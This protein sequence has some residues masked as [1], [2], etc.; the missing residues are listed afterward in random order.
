MTKD[1]FIQT[2]VEMS[3]GYDV[4]TPAIRERTEAIRRH[5]LILGD[6]M[7]AY[8]RAAQDVYDHI[9]SRLEKAK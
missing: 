4:C 5:D 2:I 8:E 1:E 9:V 6:K 7:D 3:N